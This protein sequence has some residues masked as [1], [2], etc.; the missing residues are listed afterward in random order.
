MTSK[1]EKRQLKDYEVLGVGAL[2]RQQLLTTA[3][4]AELITY[5]ALIAA[6]QS[7][8]YEALLR[9]TLAWLKP[10][11][12]RTAPLPQPVG[13]FLPEVLLEILRREFPQTAA[14][15]KGGLRELLKDYLKEV[16]WQGP[17]LSAHFRY[18]PVFLKR[19]FQDSRLYLI[20]QKEWLWTYLS[21][22]DFGL[23]PAEVGRLVVNPSLQSLY[24]E[25]EVEEVQL[26]PGLTVFYYNYA[27][28]QLGEY[29]MDLWDAAIV[30]SLQEDRKFT[31]DQLLD[32]LLMMELDSQ[33]PREEWLIKLSQ[34]QSQGIVLVL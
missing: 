24:T 31:Q 2:R 12:V 29:K 4:D 23:P 26:A 30:D 28:S 5:P 8:L 21:F 33:L 17:L 9:E 25:D 32:Q 3:F 14:Y 18:W 27:S 13:E 6:G 7:E 11:E 10:R 16:P 19:K 20:A 1:Q 15:L 34:L 22:A